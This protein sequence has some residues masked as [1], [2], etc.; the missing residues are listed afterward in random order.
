[1]SSLK[2]ILIVEDN[3]I[4]LK[5]LRDILTFQKYVVLEASE[6]ESAIK[7]IEEN[8]QTIDLILMDIQLPGMS[9]LDVITCLKSSIKYS[10]IPIIV[11]SAYAMHSD[12]EK[13]KKAGCVDYITKPINV[14]EFII[15]I[16]T[17]LKNT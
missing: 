2:K 12:I 16:N 8:F 11:I 9:G 13:S 4:N 5:L 10:K 3:P 7:I 6:G 1:L 17:F 14:Q 15:K